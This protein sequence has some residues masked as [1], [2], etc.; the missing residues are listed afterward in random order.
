MTMFEPR[1]SIEPMTFEFSPLI[2]EVMAITRLTPMVIPSTVRNERS[3]LRRSESSA[4]LTAGRSSPRRAPL[5][6]LKRQAWTP[7]LLR[8]KGDDRIQ[9]RRLGRGI[10]PEEEPHGGGHYESRHHRP[11]LNRAGQRR[12]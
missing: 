1:S 7:V 11:R 6:L 12:H 9:F 2:T 3:G 10:N 5:H 4:R 8:A